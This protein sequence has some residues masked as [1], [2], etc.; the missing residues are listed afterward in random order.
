MPVLTEAA[1]FECSRV[2]VFEE[3]TLVQKRPPDDLIVSLALG[4]LLAIARSRCNAL[5][6]HAF[7]C[8]AFEYV[9]YGGPRGTR[10]P[11]ARGVNAVL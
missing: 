11:D 9:N 5:A 10:T 2:P 6:R 1:L 7:A 3:S 8:R 4:S